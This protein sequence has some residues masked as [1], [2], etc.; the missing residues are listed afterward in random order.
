MFVEL[1][2]N[3]ISNTWG[4]LEQDGARWCKKKEDGGGISK[5]QSVSAAYTLYKRSTLE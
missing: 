2:P 1:L 3:G 4:I 5:T